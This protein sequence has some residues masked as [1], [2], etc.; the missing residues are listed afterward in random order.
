MHELEADR[1]MARE[2]WRRARTLDDLCRLGAEF[3]DGRIDFFPGW[4]SPTLDEESDAIA[5]H[6]ARFQRAGFLTVASQPGGARAATA[7][8]ASV[9]Q[10]AFVCGFASERAA[11]AL[12]SSCASP[13]LS[14]ALFDHAGGSGERAPVTLVGGVARV[15]AGYA[16]FAEELECFAGRVSD[17]ALRALRSSTYVSAIDLEWGRNSELWPFLDQALTAA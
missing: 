11:R 9:L 7:D 12:A 3:V 13:A 17:D 14:I 1:G 8:S 5:A 15:F 16:A 4:G 10:R 2:R 6:L